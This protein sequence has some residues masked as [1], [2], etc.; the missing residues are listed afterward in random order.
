MD[1][2]RVLRGREYPAT[3]IVLPCNRCGGKLPTG[4]ISYTDHYGRGASVRLCAPCCVAVVAAIGG[5]AES[6]ICPTCG[7][8]TP[9]KHALEMRKFRARKRDA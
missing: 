9:T 8:K 2:I 6:E 4:G 5:V 3:V 7:E 1:K